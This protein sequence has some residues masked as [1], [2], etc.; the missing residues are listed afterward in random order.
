MN[1]DIRDASNHMK[2]IWIVIGLISSSVGNLSLSL[3]TLYFSSNESDFSQYAIAFTYYTIIL[4]FYRPIVSDALLNKNLYRESNSREFI[5]DSLVVSVA[6]SFIGLLLFLVF[7]QLNSCSFLIMSLSTPAILLHDALRYKFLSLNLNRNAAFLDLI[8]TSCFFA[9]SASIMIAGI[10][11][12][13]ALQIAWSLPTLVT[14]LWGI[15]KLLLLD[16]SAWNKSWLITTRST[17]VQNL[18]DFVLGQGAIQALFFLAI[19][20][21]D[22]SKIAAYRIAI[23]ILFPLTL[24]QSASNLGFL[25]Y[26]ELN[27]LESSTRFSSHAEQTS[28]KFRR[29]IAL[30]YTLLAITFGDAIIQMIASYQSLFNQ[31]ILTLSSILLL[32]AFPQVD[33]LNALKKQNQYT[34]IVK[35]RKSVFPFMVIVSVSLAILFDFTGL[36]FGLICYQ[37]LFTYR[38]SRI[39]QKN[40]HDDQI[41]IVCEF[42]SGGAFLAAKNQFSVYSDS[43]Q[44]PVIYLPKDVRNS[45]LNELDFDDDGRIL[46]LKF[47][48]S[49]FNFFQVVH[50]VYAFRKSWVKTGKPKLFCHGIRSGFLVSCSTFTRPIILIHRH[51]DE[52]LPLLTRILLRFHRLYCCNLMS[53]SPVSEEMKGVIFYPILSPF[54]MKLSREETFFNQRYARPLRILWMSRLDYPK[55]PEVLLSALKEVP[56]DLYECRMIGVGPKKE[57]CQRMAIEFKLQV[58]FIDEAS[59]ISELQWANVLIH[60]SEF[61]GVPFILQEALALKV[62]VIAS[63]LPG[64]EFLGGEVFKYVENEI[65]LISEIVR[66]LDPQYYDEFFERGAKRWNEIEM[67]LNSDWKLPLK[68]KWRRR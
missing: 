4:S 26:G 3:L 51:L 65:D 55:R 47:P 35:L 62:P 64:I 16:S 6:L 50:F 45:N 32:I 68:Q 18:R 10:D 25:N 54:L 38:L 61:E 29:R 63:R 44:H 46:Y 37:I 5:R 56:L 67:K 60:L 57:L 28:R 40:Y 11:A 39:N 22:P 13:I 8:W 49:I 14:S 15:R 12:V 66:L 48:S 43:L 31:T 41:G 30:T 59:P 1:S 58:E 27:S 7:P 34:E 33:A 21:A 36:L 52:N 53:V 19:T 9:F 24:L 23:T 2:Q 20:F 17:W 42:H